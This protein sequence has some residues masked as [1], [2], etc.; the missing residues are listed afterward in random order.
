MGGMAP[1]D[2]K[3]RTSRT[4]PGRAARDELSALFQPQ[5]IAVVGA[6][7]NERSQGHEFV[8]GLVEFGFP[9]SIYPVN[10]KLTELLGLKAYARLEDIPGN[11]DFVISAVPAR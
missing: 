7:A 8:Q 11:V 1:G 5:S 6:S 4:E 3:M 9:G 2:R 10:P